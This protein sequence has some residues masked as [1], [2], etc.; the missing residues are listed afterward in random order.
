[1]VGAIVVPD[2]TGCNYSKTAPVETA[3]RR[4][5]Q[6]FSDYCR[7]IP[8]AG[9]RKNVI[10][11]RVMKRIYVPADSTARDSS[12]VYGFEDHIDRHAHGFF[13]AIGIDCGELFGRFRLAQIRDNEARRLYR[14]EVIGSG[15]MI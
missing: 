11:D 1:M 5:V 2:G 15:V 12:A 10:E 4:A 9:R 8:L 14:V 6:D 7:A 13:V 3:R